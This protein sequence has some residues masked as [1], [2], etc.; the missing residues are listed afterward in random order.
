MLERPTAGVSPVVEA[1]RGTPSGRGLAVG[2]LLWK[3][4][5]EGSTPSVPTVAVTE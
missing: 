5:V 1:V 3:L 2:R 4:K